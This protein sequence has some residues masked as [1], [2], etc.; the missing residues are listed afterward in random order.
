MNNDLAVTTDGLPD[1]A[2]DEIAELL[3]DPLYWVDGYRESR[4]AAAS[5]RYAGQFP[6]IESRSTVVVSSDASA[7]RNSMQ[8]LFEEQILQASPNSRR[9]RAPG[10]THQSILTDKGQSAAVSEA[11]E[12]VVD[13]ATGAA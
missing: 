10:A 11:I 7:T 4:E 13:R 3:R 2:K 9:L 6:D 12:W 5:W 1:S 8:N